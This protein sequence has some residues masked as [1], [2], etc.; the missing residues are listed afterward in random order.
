MPAPFIS[1]QR[2]YFDMM[3]PAGTVHNAVFLSLFE[4]AR[5][6]Y[7]KSIGVTY[8]P[9]GFDYPFLV[10]RNEVNYR[11]PIRTAQEVTVSVAI[12]K[13][14]R[15][16]VTF[17]HEIY[18]AEEALCAEGAT[19]IVRIDPDTGM[20]RPWSDRFREMVAGILAED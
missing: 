1:R 5:T 16:S 19:V 4:R 7:W 13:I 10:A 15:S 18:D 17:V 20:S 2:V 9:E 8:S 3:D 12:S 6:D 11:K 14:G